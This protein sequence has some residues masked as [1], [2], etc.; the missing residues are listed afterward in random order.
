[1]D[2]LF[3]YDTLRSRLLGIGLLIAMQ[4]VGIALVWSGPAS[5]QQVLENPQPNSFQ[6]GISTISGW[7]CNANSVQI[8]ID[9]VALL[10]AAYGTS[11]E[12][13]RTV[14]VDANNGFGVLYNWNLLSE[15]PHTV[16]LCVNG[17]CEQSVP[18][19]VSTYGPQ[20]LSG[21]PPAGFV[22]CTN[23]LPVPFPTTTFLVWQ[24]S[25]QNWAIAL[26]LTCTE[27]QTLCAPPV[28]PAIQQLCTL[29]SQCC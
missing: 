3:C 9:G 2:T 19:F 5:A 1:M 11:R 6:S 21:I 24:Q 14:C 18:V 8:L 4:T 27:I 20:F 13:T 16:A 7:V 15:G 28:D 25:Q 29:L 10:D 22:L 17:V 23:T 12:D 26:T